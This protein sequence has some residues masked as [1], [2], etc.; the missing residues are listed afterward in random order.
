MT[1]ADFSS[2]PTRGYAM[3]TAQLL[4][5]HAAV[6]VISDCGCCFGLKPKDSRLWGF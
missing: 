1:A 2:M 4:V 6:V 5:A 3:P